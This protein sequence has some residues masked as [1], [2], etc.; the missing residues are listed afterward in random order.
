MKQNYRTATASQ[1]SLHMQGLV[2][3]TWCEL[4]L[5]FLT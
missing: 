5:N 4:A 2:H 3:N 1:K